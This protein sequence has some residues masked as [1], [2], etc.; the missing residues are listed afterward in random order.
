MTIILRVNVIFVVIEVNVWCYAVTVVMLNR[1][2]RTRVIRL[3]NFIRCSKICHKSET[4]Q[5][6]WI[7]YVTINE[8]LNQSVYFDKN[9]FNMNV[10]VTVSIKMLLSIIIWNI[11]T[12]VGCFWTRIFLQRNYSETLYSNIVFI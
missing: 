7:A 6:N 4:H 12:S 9:V 1:F 8:L 3:T 5:Y 2:R 11:D 10:I